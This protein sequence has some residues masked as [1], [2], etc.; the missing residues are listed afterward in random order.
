MHCHLA[1]ENQT[2]CTGNKT[3]IPRES[4][5]DVLSWSVGH[6]TQF[7]EI[8]ECFNLVPAFRDKQVN[9]KEQGCGSGFGQIHFHLYQNFGC[10]PYVCI[11]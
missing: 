8:N 6:V 1:G 2:D 5:L 11:L 7:L 9:G 4:V 3:V 10:Y